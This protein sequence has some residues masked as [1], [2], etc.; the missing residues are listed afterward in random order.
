MT[1]AARSVESYRSEFDL[2]AKRLCGNAQAV[3]D[4]RV[5]VVDDD[6]GA[7]R[8]VVDLLQRA[9]F[10]R[11]ETAT[12]GRQGLAA[13]RRQM[14]AVLVL[15]VHMPELDG[16]AT[17]REMPCNV[18]SRG[19][20]SVL[21]LSGDPA[22]AVRRAMLLHGADDSSSDRARAPNWSTMLFGSPAGR[23][24]SIELWTA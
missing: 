11:V 14:P 18:H 19:V 7:S 22:P 23:S 8:L 15:D 13:M 21:A 1:Y 17:L 4:A 10:W 12:T 16:F 6:P 5:L 24:R 9:G 20:T 2:L 3:D